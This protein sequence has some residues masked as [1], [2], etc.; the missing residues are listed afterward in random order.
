MVTLKIGPDTN[1]VSGIDK[2]MGEERTRRLQKDQALREMD[3]IIRKDIL[4]HIPRLLHGCYEVIG[5]EPGYEYPLKHFSLTLWPKVDMKDP[6]YAEIALGTI[7]KLA[8]AL[9]KAG[10]QITKQPEAKANDYTKDMTIILEAQRI[11][12][13]SLIDRLTR[14]NAPVREVE[15]SFNFKGAHETDRCK[16]VEEE[17]TVKEH[18]VPEHKETRMVVVCNGDG[19]E[20]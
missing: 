9:E 13:P 3:T 18:Y 15:V 17:I 1:L 6:E 8:T 16:L 20:A 4:P 14:R 10:W 12:A 5:M 19:D 7:A 2:K 11:L